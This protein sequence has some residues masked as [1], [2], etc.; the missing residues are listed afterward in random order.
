MIF[1]KYPYPEP[2]ERLRRAL[3]EAGKVPDEFQ[4][5]NIGGTVKS[6]PK[7]EKLN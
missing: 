4:A 5:V 1:D 6:N 7:P 2:R 3:E